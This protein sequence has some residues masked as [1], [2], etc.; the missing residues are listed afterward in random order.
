L[1]K[2]KAT[3][4]VL[5]I[6]SVVFIACYFTFNNNQ[7]PN[8]ETVIKNQVQAKTLGISNDIE[9]FLKI[10]SDKDIKSSVKGKI[11]NDIIIDLYILNEFLEAT[12]Y[13]TDVSIGYLGTPYG[14]KYIA[15]AF[16]GKLPKEYQSG[17]FED[18]RLSEN[19][20]KFVNQLKN[21]IDGMYDALKGA[22]N[23]QEI[24]EII[25][26]FL[27]KWWLYSEQNENGISSYDL[28]LK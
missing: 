5:T 23:T 10:Y 8:K 9:D 11:Y 14:F 17:I 24:S 7:Q 26:D 22:D 16:E 4:I 21:D 27:D 28:L 25:S 3:F 2:K 13:L 18:Q 12:D 6:L 20:K 1:Y 19:E 15:Y